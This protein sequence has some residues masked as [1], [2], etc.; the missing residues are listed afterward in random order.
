MRDVSLWKTLRAVALAIALAWVVALALQNRLLRAELMRVRLHA[1]TPPV[2]LTVPAFGAVTLSGDS[3]MVGRGTAGQVLFFFS[4]ACD[5]CRQNLP[6]WERITVR[7][8]QATP[9]ITVFGLTQDPETAVRAYMAQYRV[10]F[11]VA[12]L[13]DSTL[14]LLYRADAVPLTV[15]LNPTGRVLVSRAGILTAAAVDS[16]VQSAIGTET[17]SE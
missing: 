9:G 14:A 3:V 7:A 11:D 5:F 12:R 13:R 8:L 15:V 1:H 6:A 10:A 17:R 4:S 2:G 16:I